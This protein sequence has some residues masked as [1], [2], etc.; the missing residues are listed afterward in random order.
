MDMK[1][2]CMLIF[3]SYVPYLSIICS[4]FEKYYADYCYLDWFDNIFD[5]SKYNDD[6]WILEYELLIFSLN[7]TDVSKKSEAC[8]WSPIPPNVTPAN[9][10]KVIIIDDYYPK[11]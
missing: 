8:L 3:C 1:L 6:V 10:Y 5:M 4:A 11:L 7:F 9:E 2:I